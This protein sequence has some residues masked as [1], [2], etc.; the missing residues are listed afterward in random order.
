MTSVCSVHQASNRQVRQ[1]GKQASKQRTAFSHT[2][3]K[4]RGATQATSKLCAPHSYTPPP[5][6]LKQVLRVRVVV[7]LTIVEPT[8]ARE[9]ERERR[10]RYL[11]PTRQLHRKPSKQSIKKQY[12]GDNGRAHRGL[13]D[14]GCGHR[15]HRALRAPHRR[16]ARA[17]GHAG[18]L[19]GA[20]RRLPRGAQ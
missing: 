20:R 14:R 11:T 12:G 17:A 3:R 18:V 1:V 9:R 2:N 4:T 10:A 16:A 5:L 19:P 13:R 7:V 8:R 6:T 15:A